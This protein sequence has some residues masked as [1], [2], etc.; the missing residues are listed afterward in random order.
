MVFPFFSSGEKTVISD[1]LFI[2]IEWEDG[3]SP[4]TNEPLLGLIK[5]IDTAMPETSFLLEETL[6]YLTFYQTMVLL[7]NLKRQF[8]SFQL[9]ALRICHKT[10]GKVSSQDEVFIRPLVIDN[11]FNDLLG[12][13][14]QAVLVQDSFKSY[15]YS[16]KK[17]YFTD[18]VFP[19]Y[20]ESLNKNGWAVSEEDLPEFPE[21]AET[22]QLK[23]E[24][25]ET[26]ARLPSAAAAK[27]PSWLKIV[28]ITGFVTGI[29]GLFFGFVSFGRANRLANQVHYLYTQTTSLKQVQTHEHEVD[30]FSRY[31]LAAY[32]SNDK[33]ALKPFL[34][35]GDARYTAPKDATITSTILEGISYDADSKTYTL[36]YVLGLKTKD[37][38]KQSRLT[39]EVKE[40]KHSDYGFVLT[41]E[42]TEKTYPKD[43]AN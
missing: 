31:F 18:Q 12:L 11:G 36:N 41:A 20:I 40:N 24:T 17:A 19:A 1:N 32:Y 30:T 10:D 13:L 5:G 27:T 9:K 6:P 23:E 14:M 26:Q 35:K 22:D 2:K 38:T 16:K 29:L 8:G 37:D 3:Y 43:K 28:A 21:A 42:P 7:E 33:S 25:R 34:D 4:E 39:F 15:P